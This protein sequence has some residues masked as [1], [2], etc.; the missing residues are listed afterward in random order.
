MIYWRSRELKRFLR[1][2]AGIIQQ[3]KEAASVLKKGG[4]VA[5]P[6][7]TVYGLGAMSN[8]SAAVRSIFKVKQRPLTQPL[9][10]L[11]G[12]ISQADEAAIH[13]PDIARRLMNAFWPGALTIILKRAAWIPSIITAGGNTI[14]VRVPDYALTVALIKSIDVPLVGTSANLCGWPSPKTASEVKTQLGGLVDY[15][16][17]GGTTPLG[18]E[19]TIVDATVEP[20]R[21]VREGAILRGELEKVIPIA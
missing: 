16:L 7:D 8:N 2:D 14:A 21:L 13:I 12:N 10:L 18:K 1:M 9:P 5:F 20:L 3:I 17:D 6:T 11:L 19:S 15:I 4:I